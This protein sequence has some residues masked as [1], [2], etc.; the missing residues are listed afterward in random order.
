MAVNLTGSSDAE[1][2][3]AVA[4]MAKTITMEAKAMMAKANRQIVQG[5][6]PPVR[7]MEDKI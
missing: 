3:T 6:N 7:I 4:Q 2:R 5:E 1:M